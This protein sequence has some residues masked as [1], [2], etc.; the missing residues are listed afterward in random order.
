M[1]RRP[2]A[3]A[4]SAVGVVLALAFAVQ[5][6]EPE[7]V[8]DETFPVKAGYRLA[9]KV[10]DMNVEVKTGGPEEARVEVSVTSDHARK[11]F[12]ESGFEARLEGEELVVS[13]REHRRWMFNWGI[14]LHEGSVDITVTVPERFDVS[15]QTGDGEVVAGG[16]EGRLEL[17]TSDGDVVLG[18]L[19]GPSITARTSDGDVR[20][21]EL[22]ADQ[23]E[24]KTSDGEI[25]LESVTAKEV[26]MTTSDGGIVADRVNAEVIFART[27]DGDIRLTVSGK[28]ITA[29]T[30]DGSIELTTEG[31]MAIEAHTS[32]GDITLHLPSDLDAE[33][34]LRGE[35]VRVG[36]DIR[37]KGRVDDD[38]VEGTL[39]NGG[40]KVRARTSDGVVA[41]RFD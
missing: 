41:I 33:L 20:A 24:V 37:L 14:V 39:N 31:A 19:R 32:D 1:K 12:D 10:S 8:F 5:A 28:E 13:T 11:R 6:S 27:S 2:I 22:S 29:R 38:M 36:G 3:A 15:V 30:S 4:L 7:T 21:E 17:T 25:N 26:R 40:P 23:I 9:V 18:K 34:D 16:I 35:S